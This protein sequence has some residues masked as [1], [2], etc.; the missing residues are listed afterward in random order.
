[1]MAIRNQLS[2]SSRTTTTR[3]SVFG[4]ERGD[5]ATRWCRIRRVG[6]RRAPDRR[7]ARVRAGL[8]PSSSDL[9]RWCDALDLDDVPR[10][11]D[12]V[13][14]AYRR[15]MLQKHPDAGGSEAAAMAAIEA[16]EGLAQALASGRELR[17][18]R[19]ALEDPFSA[20]ALEIEF[21]G[22]CWAFVDETRC[23][24][25]ANCSASC[26]RKAPR[27]FERASDTGSARALEREPPVE[28]GAE[29]YDEWVAATQCPMNCVHFVTRRQRDYLSGV[30]ENARTGAASWA[31]AS[32]LASELIARAGYN[33]GREAGRRAADA[34]G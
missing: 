21:D 27:S 6:A 28:D 34:R 10:T 32:A 4:R 7:D 2:G 17:S 1:M 24:G 12:D 33:N 13:R 23:V 31:D 22:A 9:A 29:A 25:E 5:E 19:E 26:V 15:T 16:R 18:A 3:A 8:N 14:S 30:L 20:T 11:V